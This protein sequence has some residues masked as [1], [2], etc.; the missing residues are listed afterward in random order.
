MSVA[1]SA[2]QLEI[3]L[4]AP[5]PGAPEPLERWRPRIA[6]W[7]QLWGVPGLEHRLRL[8]VSTRMFRSLGRCAPHKLQ[9]RIAAFLLDG[10][11]ELLE[12]VLCHEAAH[13]AAGEIHGKRV[14]PHGREWRSLMEAAGFPARLRLPLPDDLERKLE[15]RPRAAWRHRCRVCDLERVAGRPVRQWRCSKCLA[16]GR[17]G[18]LEIQRVERR[19][20]HEG[21]RRHGGEAMETPQI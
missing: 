10:P 18:R 4:A 1:A 2:Q 6:E 17:S 7:Y 9:I 19:D 13:A 16:A 11:E 20:E 21:V 12:E 3:P 15:R 14:R 5:V 8:S